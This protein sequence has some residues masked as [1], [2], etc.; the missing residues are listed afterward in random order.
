MFS[1]RLIC[2]AEEAELVSVY[3]WEQGTAG[4][5]EQEAGAEIVLIAAFESDLTRGRLLNRFAHYQPEWFEEE[6][7]DW[8]EY[9]K[10][11]WP[12]REVGDRL[13]LAPAWSTAA[14]PPG[15]HRVMH[16]PGL[17]SGTGEHPCTLLALQ[18]LERH[19]PNVARVVDIG[20]GSGIL[21]I[22]A[23]HLGAQ[24]V[25][26]LDTDLEAL[27]VAQENFRLNG[28]KRPPLVAGSCNCLGADCSTLTVANIDGT[29]LLSMFDDLLR[30]TSPNGRLILTGF[31]EWE[32]AAFLNLLP[33]AAVSG[34]NEW[35]CLVSFPSEFPPP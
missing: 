5:R 26:A 35:R 34:M 6:S 17:A 20:T 18:A 24:E 19:S 7:I 14:T 28:F 30:V 23:L 21:A 13:F 33:G 11:S 8:A 27:Q 32:L 3:L 10:S 25:L 15:R 29:V 2:P 16:S 12:A 1:L 4:I 31:P 22:A 9:V